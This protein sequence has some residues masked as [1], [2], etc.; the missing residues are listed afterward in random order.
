MME[1]K[2]DSWVAVNSFES[3]ATAHS[4]HSAAAIRDCF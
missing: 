1:F 2:H 4:F 3:R